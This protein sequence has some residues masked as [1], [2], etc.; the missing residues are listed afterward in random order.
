[1]PV[2]CADRGAARLGKGAGGWC[3]FHPM[4]VVIRRAGRSDS[5]RGSTRCWT[6]WFSVGQHVAPSELCPWVRTPSIVSS[7]EGS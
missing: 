6:T 5:G 7:A 3:D 1:M 4:R 2:G